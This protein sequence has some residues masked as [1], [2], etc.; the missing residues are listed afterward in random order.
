MASFAPV[1]G[2]MKFETEPLN[3][4]NWRHLTWLG[5]GWLQ[6][7]GGF[8][9]VGLTLWILNGMLNPVYDHLPDG[10]KRNRLVG[11]GM[12]LA[13]AVALTIYLV[14]L[15]LNILVAEESPATPRSL[16]LGFLF[17]KM[18]FA[19]EVTLA[20]AG[21][22]A[23]LGFAGPFVRDC[24]RMRWSRIYAIAKLSFKEAVRWR[25][26]WVFFLIL[27]VYLFPARWFFQEKPEDEVKSIIG[28]TIRGMNLLLIFVALLL[29]SFSIPTDIKNLTI[30]TVVTKPVERFE[31]VLGRFFGYL[32]LVTAALF[33]MTLFGLL[34]INVGNV[35]DEA[36]EESMKAR[37]ALYGDLEFRSK[38]SADFTGI[39]VGREDAYRRYIAG[40]PTSSQR[41]VWNFTGFPSR[42]TTMDNVPL[43][44]A[45]DIYRTTKGEE[46]TGVSVSFEVLSHRWD[47][48]K[49]DE[50]NSAMQGLTN[51]KPGDA[52]WVKVDAV[53]EK[54]GR[55]VYRN[56]QIFDYHT[57][58]ISVPAGLFRNAAQGTPT[59]DGPLHRA[60][61]AAPVPR[62][63]VLAKCETPSQFIGAARYDLYFLES[64]GNFSWNYFKGSL[65]LWFRLAIAIAIAVACSTYL[66]GVL[67]FLVSAAVFVGGF[68]LDFITELARGMNIGGGPLESLARLIKNQTA[69]VE[70]DPS[71]TVKTIQ[72]FDTAY[73]WLLRRVM[74]V[75]PDVDRF[76]LTDYVAQGFSIG[77]GFLLLNL[78]TLVAYVLPWL[79]AAYYLM[80]AREIAA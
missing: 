12:L 40:H 28:V 54:Y 67:S 44:F 24:L 34:L 20:L 22:V 39:D 80:K 64:E 33:V 58:S 76:G 5:I 60:H 9:M 23:L 25:V 49:E 47:P 48:T 51:V 73:R 43:E 74:N 32:G 29:A 61:P 37:V 7:A 56:W 31:I 2:V 45:F 14:A 77:P 21:L 72:V 38:K 63:Q 55:Y 65:G 70:L 1:L 11:P 66:A 79:V 75:I 69:T 13:A 19:F 78:I 30:H 52:N 8:A 16:F 15:G 62:V 68:F 42:F 50:F 35:A 59:R 41:A 6:D 3:F 53:A 10:R 46:G 26:V 57:S 71:P 18:E 36:A 17:T 4:E 27:I